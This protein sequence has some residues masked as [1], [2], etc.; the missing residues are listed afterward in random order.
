M[1]A[2]LGIHNIYHRM[3]IEAK[4]SDESEFESKRLRMCASIGR[5][6]HEHILIVFLLIV[7]HAHLNQHVEDV[8]TIPYQGKPIAGGKGIIYKMK[9]IPLD[10]QRIIHSYIDHV[11]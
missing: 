6:P 1:S 10:L 4:I 5:L 8:E 9:E 2:D 11:S 3:S 7:Y